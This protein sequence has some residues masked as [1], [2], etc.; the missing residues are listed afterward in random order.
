VVVTEAADWVA[1]VAE[2]AV[3][4]DWAAAEAAAGSARCTS[5]APQ[6]SWGTRDTERP[7]SCSGTPCTSTGTDTP[8]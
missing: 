2:E 8:R 1:V 6:S 5:P 3:V 7:T 4:E